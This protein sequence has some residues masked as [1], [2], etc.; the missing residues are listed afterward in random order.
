MIS[1]AQNRERGRQH[2]AAVGLEMPKKG[3]ILNPLGC[4]DTISG[5]QVLWK[6]IWLGTQKLPL[7]FLGSPPPIRG[8]NCSRVKGGTWPGPGEKAR[9]GPLVP[10]STTR[11]FRTVPEAIVEAAAS[12]IS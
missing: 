7:T 1:L 10:Q 9:N 2:F 5:N 12:G 6:H 8:E 3:P 11:L 4:I